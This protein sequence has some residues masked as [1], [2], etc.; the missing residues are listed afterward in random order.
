MVIM[1]FVLSFCGHSNSTATTTVADSSLYGEL[2][3]IDSETLM[4]EAEENIMKDTLLACATMALTI[5]AN[6][7]YDRPKDPA[8]RKNAVTA[9][10]ELGN[11]YFS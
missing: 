1:A 9:L 8:T 4:A 6:R 2:C 3:A 7:Y 5:V 11:F 10:R